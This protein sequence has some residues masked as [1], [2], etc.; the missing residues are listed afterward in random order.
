MSTRIKPSPNTPE[1][2]QIQKLSHVYLRH[3]DPEAFLTFAAAFGFEEEARDDDAVYLRGYGVD[4]YCY[5]VLGKERAFEGG[6]WT[7]KSREDLEKAMRLPGATRRD[8]VGVPGAGELVSVSSPGG[9]KMHLLWGQQTRAAPST[10]P[11]A[12]VVSVGPANHPFMKERKGAFQRF[13]PGPAMIHKL[14][15][16]GYISS[17]FDADLAF[18]LDNFNL[19]PS[20]ILYDPSQPALDILAFLHVDLGTEFSD[21]H[22]LFIQ[23]AP[24]PPSTPPPPSPPPSPPSLSSSPATDQTP[25]SHPHPHP[26]PAI[27]H[28]TSFEV[29]D[30]DT[31]LL[32]HQWLATQPG[33]HAPV[34]GVG[35]HV[36]GSQIF[37][38]W[39]DPSGFKIEHYADGDEV[40]CETP[41]ARLPAGPDTLSV[42]GP[43]LPVDFGEAD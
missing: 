43:P 9:T 29:S 21:H 17:A 20:D 36:L 39:R 31:Q 16:Y 6:A 15:H 23:R 12:Q 42:W 41:V 11:S 28:H 26:P 4:P 40:N 25:N 13:K 37:D 1:K 30:F 22:S 2:I 7:V 33:P 19:T 3:A 32:G 10:E 35:R 14:G 24:T 8:L 27:M 34:W 5:V 38:Y 18:Y